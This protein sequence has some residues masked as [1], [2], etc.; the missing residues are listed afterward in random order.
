MIRHK[1]V[2]SCT[3]RDACTAAP[4]EMPTRRPSSKA[5]RLAISTL[6]SLEICVSSSSRG[7][8]CQRMPG[9]PTHSFSLSLQ[10]SYRCTAITNIQN[11]NT[12]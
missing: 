10:Q 7:C 9:E 12:S 4:E 1:N 6:S 8:Q 2:E 5:S 3:C 11:I